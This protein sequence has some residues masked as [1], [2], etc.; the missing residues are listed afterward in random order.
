MGC[1]P[2]V[3]VDCFLR[4]IFNCEHLTRRVPTVQPILFA[5]S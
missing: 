5:I 3:F 4:L 1:N 2:T